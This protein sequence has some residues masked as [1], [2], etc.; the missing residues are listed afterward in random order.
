L[1]ERKLLQTR[2]SNKRKKGLYI[3]SCLG[4]FDVNE[5]S[6]HDVKDVCKYRLQIRNIDTTTM[7][8]IHYHFGIK[9]N[10]H[11]L[12]VLGMNKVRLERVGHNSLQE[13]LK[14]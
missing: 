14:L 5:S 11:M 6:H 13:Y 7:N 12:Q 8:H 10:Y 1:K 3:Y 2:V 9:F 4:Q